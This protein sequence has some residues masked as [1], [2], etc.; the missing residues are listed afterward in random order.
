[1]GKLGWIDSHAHLV[2]ET[3]YEHIDD[4][5]EALYDF[6][7]QRVLSIST[8]I[9]EAY[10]NF[11]LQQKY[12]GIDVALGFHPSDAHIITEQ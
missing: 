5:I 9:E 2:D 1:M 12:D 10:L 3:L 4:V 6:N 8:T 7:V 11:D